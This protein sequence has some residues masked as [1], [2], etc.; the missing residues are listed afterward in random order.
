MQLIFVRHGESSANAEGRLQG[1]RDYPL[2]R[3]G[4]AQ[5]LAF[6]AWSERVG[7]SWDRAYCSPLSRACETADII[8]GERKV[9]PAERHADFMEFDTGALSGLLHTQLRRRHPEYFER[10]LDEHADYS[11]WG[12]EGYRQ[13]QQRAQRVRSMLEAAH[14]KTAECVLVVGHGG[15]G[16][17][18]IKHLVCEPLP[19]VLNMKLGNCTAL[20]VRMVEGFQTYYGQLVWHVPVELMRA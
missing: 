6:A 20:L 9:Q 2:T 15:F 5:A 11:R 3:R 19:R 14:R 18:L 7:L 16:L 12:G 4:R 1:Q 13:V 10:K 17:Q 8:T